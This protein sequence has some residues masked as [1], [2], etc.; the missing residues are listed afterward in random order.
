MLK[1]IYMDYFFFSFFKEQVE[2]LMATLRKT[3]PHF[4]RCIIPNE[5]KEAGMLLFVNIFFKIT[6][7]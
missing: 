7:Y 3:F 2:N 5:N 4:I 1:Y 6:T